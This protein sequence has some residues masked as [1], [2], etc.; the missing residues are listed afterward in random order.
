MTDLAVIILG[1]LPFIGVLIGIH[2]AQES[3]RQRVHTARQIAAI[4]AVRAGDDR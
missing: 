4:D 1:S 3:E 2:M